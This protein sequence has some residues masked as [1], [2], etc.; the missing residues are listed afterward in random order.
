MK[1]TKLT[2]WNFKQNK[3]SL[4]VDDIIKEYPDVNPDF[5]YTVLLQRGVFKWLSVRRDIIKLKNEMLSEV[6][7]LNHK[8]T[9]EEKGYYKAIIKW[10][11]KIRKLCHSA[12]WVAPDFDR[13]ANKFLN[14]ASENLLP[15]NGRRT[16]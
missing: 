3:P 14:S 11:G 12:R 9:P 16:K 6:R 7:N 1:C 10:R 4:I 13:K 15:I 5:I 8:K 2:I